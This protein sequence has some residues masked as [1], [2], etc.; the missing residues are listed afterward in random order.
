LEMRTAS[1][2]DG[3]CKEVDYPVIRVQTLPQELLGW[4][5]RTEPHDQVRKGDS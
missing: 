3:H 5:R 1:R 4:K 2:F